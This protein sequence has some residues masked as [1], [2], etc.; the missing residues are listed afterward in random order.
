MISTRDMLLLTSSGPG[1]FIFVTARK[2]RDLSWNSTQLP[3]S[4]VSASS[5]AMCRRQRCI[6]PA[7]VP[8]VVPG[9]YAA[10]AHAHAH[11]AGQSSVSRQHPSRR[12]RQ[13]VCGH[14]CN[15]T[16]DGT[17]LCEPGASL[18]HIR[19]T[20]RMKRVTHRERSGFSD[21]GCT[22]SKQTPPCSRHICPETGGQ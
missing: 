22:S 4:S 8:G 21:H 7:L 14:S 18:C 2:P 10:H 20:T 9:L 1:L 19:R 12:R 11:D 17:S 16:D 15:H 5:A 13:N 3:S 6:V